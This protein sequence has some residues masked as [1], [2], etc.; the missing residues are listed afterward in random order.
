M[1]NYKQISNSKFQIPKLKIFF[2][3]T[4]FLILLGFGFIG[5][6]AAGLVINNYNYSQNSILTFVNTGGSIGSNVDSGGSIIY[7]MTVSNPH[8]EALTTNLK[9]DLPAG[10]EFGG[11]IDDNGGKA[12]RIGSN[13]TG[14]IQWSYEADPGENREYPIVFK[15]I[16]P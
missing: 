7:T 11:M 14:T 16:A 4:L 1:T 13:T 9:F 15:I 8:W 5:V 3:T 6:K 2:Y 12:T 10:F